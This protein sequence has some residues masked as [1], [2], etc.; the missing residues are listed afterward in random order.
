MDGWIEMME[1]G[2]MVGR[3]G[4]A[5]QRYFSCNPVYHLKGIVGDYLFSF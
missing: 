4:R 1:E 2:K 5:G 3:Q